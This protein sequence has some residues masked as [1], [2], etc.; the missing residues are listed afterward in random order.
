MTALFAIIKARNSHFKRKVSMAGSTQECLQK[1]HR[2]AWPTF[3]LR[4]CHRIFYW[5][6]V[7]DNKLM[8]CSGNQTYRCWHG[9]K[10]MVKWRPRS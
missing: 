1:T 2:V 3:V 5:Y 4:I 9:S 10:S 7:G 8:K 6:G